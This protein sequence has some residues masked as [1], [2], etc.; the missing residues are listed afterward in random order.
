MRDW[1]ADSFLTGNNVSYT[2][3]KQT[4][5]AFGYLVQFHTPKKV[6]ISKKL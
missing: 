4:N 2:E 3:V 6:I 1:F 5:N